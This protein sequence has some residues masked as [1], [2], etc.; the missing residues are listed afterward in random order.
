MDATLPAL[1][2]HW[3]HSPDLTSYCW[4]D[5]DCTNKMDMG[6][7]MHSGSHIPPLDGKIIKYCL[8]IMITS[9][10]F[11]T[12]AYPLCPQYC[13]MT[14]RVSRVFSAF[15]SLHKDCYK[16]KTPTLCQSPVASRTKYWTVEITQNVRNPCHNKG[17]QRGKLAT[18]PY[19]PQ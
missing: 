10:T 9:L 11:T 8:Y 1:A 12:A 17:L 14:I 3:C 5:R 2:P 16:G 4:A 18:L 13:Y 15:T 6:Q 19:L 7:K